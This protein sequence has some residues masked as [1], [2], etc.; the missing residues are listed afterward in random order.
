M[1]LIHKC[2]VNSALCNAKELFAAGGNCGNLEVAASG[3]VIPNRH[4]SIH[5]FHLPSD[6]TTW[7]PPRS[8]RVSQ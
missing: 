4:R 5:A 2:R 3:A 7:N 1:P 6:A 8:D